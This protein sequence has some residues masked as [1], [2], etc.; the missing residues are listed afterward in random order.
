MS[1]RTLL[2]HRATTYRRR[3]GT[4]RGGQPFISNPEIHLANLACRYSPV[5]RSGGRGSG[6]EVYSGNT[7]DIV[8]ERIVVFF[9]RWPDIIEQDRLTVVDSIGAVLLN[10]ANISLVKKVSS[11][12]GRIHHLEIIVS[13]QR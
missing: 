3:P 10:Q 7:I 8:E 12:R 1:F 9:W 11:G 2:T 5:G 4:D 6:G 13:E